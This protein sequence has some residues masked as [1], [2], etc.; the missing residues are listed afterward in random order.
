MKALSSLSSLLMLALLAPVSGQATATELHDEMLLTTM[1]T[2]YLAPSYQ[3]TLVGIPTLRW[4]RHLPGQRQPAGSSS[5][6]AR[7]V[8]DG[9]YIFVGSSGADSLFRIERADGALSR[10]YPA[11]APVRAAPCLLED[12]VLFSDGAGYTWLYERN[13]STPTWRNFAGAPILSTP[14]LGSGVVYLAAVDSV[15][16]ALDL[17]TGESLWRYSHP[18]DR[19]RKSELELFGAPSPLLVENQLLVGFHDGS[20]VSLDPE[21]GEANWERR[22]GEGRYPDIIGEPA[23]LDGIVFVGGFSKPFVA[24]DTMD[25]SI[26]WSLDFGTAVPPALND[27]AIYVAGTDGIL[28][29]ADAKTGDLLWEWD[30][31]HSGAL[32][33]P[34]LS[35]L[36]L[37]VGASDGG[38]WLL[39]PEDGQPAWELDPGMLISGISAAPVIAGRQLLVLT[40]AGQLLSLVAPVSNTRNEHFNGGVELGSS[41]GFRGGS[42]GNQP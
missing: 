23:F 34:V 40:N 7:P 2:S 10:E 8:V 22:V 30:S 17:E 32:T 41:N 38:L 1:G 29:A 13:A 24:L 33:M 42:I 25:N 14:A 11:G 26:V 15:V 37:F 6:L 36:G 5:E 16:H 4:M 12:S 35:P 19:T 18:V 27:D 20:V 3:G 9:R 31:H 21:S 28:R 39:D